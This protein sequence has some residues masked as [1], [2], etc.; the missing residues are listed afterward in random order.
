MV[1]TVEHVKTGNPLRENSRLYNDPVETLG[2]TKMSS[3]W[4][5]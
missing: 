4:K 1:A 3:N 5:G 2:N